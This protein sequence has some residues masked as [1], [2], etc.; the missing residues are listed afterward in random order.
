M[1]DYRSRYQHMSATFWLLAGATV[2]VLAAVW[3]WL[4]LRERPGEVSPGGSPRPPGVASPAEE[5]G[6]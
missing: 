3:A 5:H 1:S 6:E 4:L 2:L